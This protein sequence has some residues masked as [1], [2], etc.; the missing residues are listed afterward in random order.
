MTG[1]ILTPPPPTPTPPRSRL[2][3]FL[4]MASGNLL[5]IVGI[6]LILLVLLTF[7]L[8]DEAGK[9]SVSHG[10][11]LAFVLATLI[12]TIG[13][14]VW[15]LARDNWPHIAVSIAFIG[16]PLLNWFWWTLNSE[17]WDAWWNSS[18]FWPM[19]FTIIF[20]AVIAGQSHRSAKVFRV[21]TAV[22]MLIAVGMGSYGFT[23]KR[24]C[25]AGADSVWA[26]STHTKYKKCENGGLFGSAFARDPERTL[27]VG[28]GISSS[29]RNWRDMKGPD[30]DSVNLLV[31]ASSLSPE[32]QDSVIRF[33]ACESEYTQYSDSTRSLA[34]RGKK[35]SLDRGAAQINIGEHPHL[36]DSVETLRANVA[37]AIGLFQEHGS[38]PWAKTRGCWGNGVQ[39]ADTRL[40]RTVADVTLEAQ[41]M[42]S[43]TDT[44]WSDTVFTRG[45]GITWDP[46]GGG[47]RFFVKAK[48]FRSA[49]IQTFEMHPERDR[50]G[51]TIDFYP[52]WVLFAASDRTPFEV[53][54]TLHKVIS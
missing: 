26:D 1:P 14:L 32:E 12:P 33:I 8:G 29:S 44:V 10:N 36:K 43:P 50:V 19:I 30:Q 16:V 34:L 20:S 53:D 46:V 41:A 24:Y 48:K 37:A 47:R 39:V 5:R 45:R 3:G 17:T 2:A 9:S 15:R 31:R 25:I 18:V 23:T 13:I 40:V 51:N 54:V 42:A 35:D 38:T 27:T 49:T 22:L 7:T 4:Q 28:S 11:T 21:L 52:E 6:L